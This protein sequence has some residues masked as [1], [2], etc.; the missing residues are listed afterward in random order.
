M[1]RIGW[2]APQTLNIFPFCSSLCATE[3][4]S[5]YQSVTDLSVLRLSTAPVSLLTDLAGKA[6][7]GS[8]DDGQRRYGF[9]VAL[10]NSQVSSEYALRLRGEIEQVS[11]DVFSPRERTKIAPVLAQISETARSLAAVGEEGLDRLANAFA[12]SVRRIMD[13]IS[14]LEY[15]VDEEEFDSQ[16]QSDQFV[17]QLMTDLDAKCFSGLDEKLTRT[18]WDGIVRRIAEW[19]AKR[20]EI[21]ILPPGENFGDGKKFNALGALRLDRDVRAISAFF[22]GKAQ[23]GTVRDVFTRLSQIAMLVNLER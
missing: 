11:S 9:S 7:A 5:S 20:V 10:N 21:A 17:R 14:S 4:F 12:N 16:D 6:G 18:N 8:T 22:S 19:A 23:R 15:V 1:L 13:R 2:A 3:R